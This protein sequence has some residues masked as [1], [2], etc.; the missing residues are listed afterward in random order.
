MSLN[1][2][3]EALFRS[4]PGEWID[5]RKLAEVAGYAAWRTRV[6][7]LRCRGM[8]IENDWWVMKEGGKTFRVTVYRYVPPVEPEQLPLSDQWSVGA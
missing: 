3:L 7:N 1:D 2:R 8:D 6:S 5:G 4:R